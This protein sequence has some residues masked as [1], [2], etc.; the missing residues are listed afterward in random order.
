[1]QLVIYCK[2]CFKRNA[3]HIWATDRVE[4]KM[5]YG[6]NIEVV[7]KKCKTRLKYQIGDIQAEQRCVSFI[8]FVGLILCIALFLYFLW[9]YSW[10]KMGSVYLI[11]V[12]LLVLVS[13]YTT[14]NKEA[15]KKIRNFNR[16]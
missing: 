4:L 16:S 9:D 6:N 3:L 10:H 7:C 13:I 1:M 2:K 5:M 14:I 8:S 15:T 12:G 11:P